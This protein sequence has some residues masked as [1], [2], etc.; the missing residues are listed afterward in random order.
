M[1]PLIRQLSL[2]EL[3]TQICHQGWK[4]M[5]DLDLT[6]M[7]KLA[8]FPKAYSIEASVYRFYFLKAQVFASVIP[9][10]AVL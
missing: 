5:F 1:V 9:V 3:I 2:Q 10:A 8:F 7:N 6:L 4:V